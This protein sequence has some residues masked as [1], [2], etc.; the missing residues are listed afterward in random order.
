[1]LAELHRRVP[2]RIGRQLLDVMRKTIRQKPHIACRVGAGMFGIPVVD[3][4]MEEPY[5]YHLRTEDVKDIPLRIARM[6]RYALH[7]LRI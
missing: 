5:R 4:R 3:D 7:R 6:L 1:M 2:R